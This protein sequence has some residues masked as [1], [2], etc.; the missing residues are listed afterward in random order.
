MRLHRRNGP[1]SQESSES[2]GGV[3]ILKHGP[4]EFPGGSVG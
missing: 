4:Q 3:V 2:L 1:P